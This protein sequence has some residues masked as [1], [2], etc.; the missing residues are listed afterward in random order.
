MNK[1]AAYVPT[2]ISELRAV[3]ALDSA[4]LK[5]F[6]YEIVDLVK[7]F[8]ADEG[9]DDQTDRSCLDDRKLIIKIWPVRGPWETGCHTLDQILRKI[10]GLKKFFLRNRLL[11]YQRHILELEGAKK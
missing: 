6:G 8:I 2:S 7:N 5:K 4:N 3:G 9:F 10:T 11:I 1:I